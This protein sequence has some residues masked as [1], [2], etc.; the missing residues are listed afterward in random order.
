[1]RSITSNK[2][3]WVDT[4]LAEEEEILDTE[5]SP[6]KGAVVTFFSF[7]LIGIVPLSSYILATLRPE[8]LPYAFEIT[9]TLTFLATFSLGVVKSQI[10]QV[11][12]LWSG[13]E[14]LLCGGTAAVIAY[15]VGYLLSDFDFKTVGEVIV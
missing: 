10:T 6:V 5:I 14:M 12:W 2:K 8:V 4:L 15:W 11:G 3:L 1:M 9:I 7:F 13:C